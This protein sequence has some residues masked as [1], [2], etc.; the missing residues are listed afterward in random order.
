[1]N[2]KS[3]HILRTKL[4]NADDKVKDIVL[5]EGQPFF[6]ITTNKLYVGDGTKKISDLK[7]VGQEVDDSLQDFDNSHNNIENGSGNLS[8]QQV[9]NTSETTISIKIKN[10]NAFAQGAPEE[11]KIGATGVSTAVFGG[12]AAATGKRAFAAGTNTVALGEHSAAF[13]DNSVTIGDDS[14][15]ANYQNTAT[16]KGSTAFGTGNIS[17]G[18]GSFV[19]GAL[20]SHS[21]EY[22]ISL[23]QG[24]KGT[25]NNSLLLGN[26]LTDSATGQ[27]V[28]GNGAAKPNIKAL[29]SVV[30]AKKDE[31]AYIE[32]E[33]GDAYLL[34]NLKV[35]KEISTPSKITS[36]DS[37][38]KS[39]LNVGLNNTLSGD[40]TLSSPQSS[41]VIGQENTVTGKNSLV[42]GNN[43]ITRLNHQFAFGMSLDTGSANTAPSTTVVGFYNDP[44][45]GDVFQVGTGGSSNSRRNAFR[46]LADGRAKVFSKAEEDG[47][48]LR[49]GDLAV[50]Q[51]SSLD[52]DVTSTTGD[53]ITGVKFNGD[54]L[55]F[56]KS[57]L[58]TLSVT[59]NTI[60]DVITDMSADGHTIKLTRSSLSGGKTADSGYYISKVVPDGLKIQVE[61]TAIPKVNVNPIG[62]GTFVTK[63][64]TNGHGI[65]YTLGNLNDVGGYTQPVFTS[66]NGVL[67]TC[68]FSIA[69]D[70]LD[71]NEKKDIVFYVGA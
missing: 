52:S 8:T 34:Q 44:K 23:G 31:V 18:K 3:I 42:A 67:T 40:Y 2:N 68:S 37:V 48:V 29:I 55:K 61:Q 22:G 17:I 1:M 6:N 59:D 56:T 43:S 35:E 47:D 62:S 50:K 39:S 53:Y 20:S 46:V 69:V 63:I 14:F 21:G 51:V 70:G 25:F 5:N 64:T 71:Y 13:G 45:S 10:P 41:L 66:N 32:K 4:L 30:T 16:G 57:T 24:N 54:T 11:V 9:K 7:Y 15:T 28:F 27:I 65:E 19:A 60:G 26:N 58:P 38:I 12:A 49:W 33:T 36:F